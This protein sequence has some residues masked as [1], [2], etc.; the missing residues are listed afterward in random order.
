MRW[1]L[2]WIF[3]DQDRRMQAKRKSLVV[4]PGITR[5]FETAYR[6]NWDHMPDW[7][8]TR[9]RCANLQNPAIN[10]PMWVSAVPR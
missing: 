2:A 10:L 7:L 3:S 5:A 1:N 8:G 9:R 4:G 6:A